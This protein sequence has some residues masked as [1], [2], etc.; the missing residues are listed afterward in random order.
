MKC[1]GGDDEMMDRRISRRRL[2]QMVTAG[3]LASWVATT[4]AA[5]AIDDSVLTEVSAFGLIDDAQFEQLKARREM[6]VIEIKGGQVQPADVHVGTATV[7]VF[8]NVDAEDQHFIYITPDPNNDLAAR[9]L[10][11]MITPGGRW[12]ATFTNGE[13]PFHCA[14][15]A[16]HTAEAGRIYVQ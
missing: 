6:S 3:G 14:T 4:G 2:L 13:Y 8:H 9:V 10:T 12:A 15:H 11:G 1:I 5:Q 16:D 7:V